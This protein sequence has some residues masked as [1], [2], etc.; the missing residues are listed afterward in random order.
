[1]LLDNAFRFH[2]Y[3]EVRKI[4][5]TI[6]SFAYRYRAIFFIVGLASA[7]IVGVLHLFTVSNN[8]N[9][10]LVTRSC[11]NT[12]QKAFTDLETNTGRM[13]SATL[14]VLLTNK[15]IGAQFAKRDRENLYRLTRPV[16]EHL[17]KQD[18]I[19]HWYFLNPEPGRTCF[20]RVH[21][22]HK[23]NDIISRVT[24]DTSIKTKKIA[25]GKELG[26]TA[27]A[28]RAVR[29]YYY[30]NQLI[31]YI[32]LGIEMEDFFKVLSK[33]TGNEYGLLIK[34]EF[35]DESKWASLTAEKKIPNNWDDMEHLLLVNQ[36]SDTIHLLQFKE[37]FGNPGHIPD[38]GIVLEK[39][40]EN[41]RHFARGIFPFY[42]AAGRK[43]GGVFIRKDITPI[44][45]AMQEQKQEIVLMILFFMGIITFFMVFFHKRAE[46]ELRNY[47]TRLEEMVKESTAE[48]LE[49][50]KRLNL[51]IEEHKQVQ[52]ALQD[53]C[54]AREEAEEKQ[55]EAVKHAERSARMASI[56]VMAAGVTHEINQP[57][58]AIKV[59]ADSI[60][61]WHRRNPGVLPQDFVDQLGIITK[62]V[63]RIVE[64][65]QHMR[66]F[67]VVPHARGVSGVNINRA[68]KNALSLTR[69]QIL[70]HG[71]NQRFQLDTA[72]PAP[73]FKG[74]IIHIEQI[75]V[76]LL[77]NAIRALDE[78]D[79]D[80]KEITVTT[81]QQ[82]RWVVLEIADNGPGLPEVDVN[83][84][85]DPFF[86]TNTGGEGMGLGLA[87][88]K[89][90]ID[91]Y[92][93]T[94][95]VRNRPE[96]GAVFTVKFPVTANPGEQGMEKKKEK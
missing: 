14:E 59:T 28:L 36:T 45:N 40:T 81:Q 21:A 48:L 89:R 63:K 1:M 95:Q 78:K 17:K 47:R 41:K 49:I 54:K 42:D 33:Q 38:D 46:K 5:E 4:V 96:G 31:G 35:L 30:K 65:I 23:Y 10:E 60:Q 53:Q 58:N 75:I 93:G 70:A 80:N 13:L 82:D 64:I 50:N 88:V 16:F 76:N 74:N 84:L 22:H 24:M 37:K 8:H 32:E 91:K 51:E 11:L 56:G 29:P 66:A 87:I 72:S 26:K 73:V 94:I 55:L 27:L 34:K 15:E 68:V 7:G 18:N 71:I 83:K 77:V 39:L 62:S 57:L 69:Q 79:S 86:S 6:K 2:Y 9:V 43:V 25:F 67:W 52:E 12:A 20:L 44:Y 61:Y 90:Y 3:K 92:N 85:F 19:T